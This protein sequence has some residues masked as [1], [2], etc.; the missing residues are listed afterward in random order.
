MERTTGGVGRLIRSKWAKAGLAFI[1][2]N[3]IRGL[4][5]VASVAGA[6]F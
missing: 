6:Y 2:L 1:I 5:V 4:I 3:E